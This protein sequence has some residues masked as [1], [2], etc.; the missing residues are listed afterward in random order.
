MRKLKTLLT[1]AAMVLFASV[2]PT[3]CSDDS[4]FP[5]NVMGQIAIHSCQTTSNTA[6]IF[7]TIVSNENCDGY[8]ITLREGTR[9]N[10]GAVVEDLTFDKYTR[11]YTFENLKPATS[12]VVITQGIPGV[13]SGLVDALPYYKEFTTA[14]Q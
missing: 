11:N 9:A 1:L 13:A 8:K 2:L 14:A 12:Y 7:W 5:D 3:S 4:D 10:L 6:T